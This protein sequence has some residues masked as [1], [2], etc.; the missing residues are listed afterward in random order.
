MIR[1]PLAWLQLRREP[2]RLL[3]ALAGVAF[4]VILVSMQL[5]LQSAL[6][7]SA[8]RLH[9]LLTADLVL[10]SP[11]SQYL[12]AMKSFS[13]RRLYQAAGF[14][15]VRSVEPVYAGMVPWKN[16]VTGKPRMI[17][18]VGFDPVA[19]AFNLPEVSANLDK[20]RLPDFV[21]FDRASR[22]EF[23]PVVAEI[24]DG[25][26]VA[27]EVGDHRI[28]VAG[29]FDLGTSFGID[30]TLL[31]SDFNFL[32]IFS[33][34]SPGPIEIGLITLEP[35]ADADTVR[36]SLAAG[37]PKDVEVLTKQQYMQ[38]EI[39]Y[40]AEATPIGFVL[41]F[42]VIMGLVVG[43]V[44]VYQILFTDVA[45][46]L[47]E[48]ATLKAMGYTNRF[49]FSVVFQEAILLAVLGYLPGAA[50]VV[51]LFQVTENATRLPVAM[52]GRLGL[53]VFGLTL[54]MCC[55]AGAVALRKVRSADPAEI[56]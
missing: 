32:R 4:A 54:A 8:V 24:G 44:I 45:T 22:P 46:H 37:L 10:I 53:E 42:G 50:A 30:G 49:L 56:F 3:V 34:R 16:P 35:G 11:S 36:Q 55:T 20:I 5:G 15:G 6:F 25:N 40:W 48:Y 18:V 31:T 12:A 29:L 21:L 13:R 52:T 41:G 26:A 19:S 47:P 51:W 33:Q 28:S 17:F 1:L 38:R 39:H 2:V 23:G 43:G 27:T 14:P 7:K 9:N